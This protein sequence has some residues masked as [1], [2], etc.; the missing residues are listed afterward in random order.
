MSSSSDLASYHSETAFMA[1]SG[2]H[3]TRMESRSAVVLSGRKMSANATAVGV[4]YGSA[5]TQNSTFSNIL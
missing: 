2:V 3:H 4:R 1:R 5:T